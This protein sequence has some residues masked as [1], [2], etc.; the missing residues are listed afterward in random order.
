MLTAGCERKVDTLTDNDLGYLRGLY[1]M[2]AD[3]TARSQQDE[4]AYQME[5]GK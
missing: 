1:K 2:N 5:Q 4:I 3:W